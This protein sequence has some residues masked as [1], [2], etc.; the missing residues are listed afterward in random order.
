MKT[1]FNFYVHLYSAVD[2]ENGKPRVEGK[3][4]WAL[5]INLLFVTMTVTAI[6]GIFFNIIFNIFFRGGK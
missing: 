5:L 4:I 2:T 6:T 3:R 1:I